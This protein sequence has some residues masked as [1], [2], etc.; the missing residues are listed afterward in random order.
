M[1][2][3]FFVAL[4]DALASLFGYQIYV[5]AVGGPGFH[6]GGVGADRIYFIKRPAGP[7]RPKALRPRRA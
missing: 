2:P 3:W 7:P 5:R 6:R 1:F 4:V